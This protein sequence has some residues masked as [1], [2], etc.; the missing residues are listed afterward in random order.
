M[1]TSRELHNPRSP[2]P[3]SAAGPS[4]VDQAR[5]AYAAWSARDLDAFV[6]VFAEDVELRPFLGAGLGASKYRGHAG[7]RRWFEEA[8]EAW[9][10]LR[11]EPYEFREAG[12]RIAVFLRAIG[13]GRGSHVEV[14]AEIVHVA[15]FR[16]GKFTRLEGFGDRE[17]ALKALDQGA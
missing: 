2:G 14:E 4:K 9:D 17:Q 16:D 12:D 8:N 5:A 13:R 1:G 10:E 11:I 15:D 7:L 3:G 6:K